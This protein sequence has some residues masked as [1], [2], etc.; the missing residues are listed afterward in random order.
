[1]V[2]LLQSDVALFLSFFGLRKQAEGHGSHRSAST[3]AGTAAL[4]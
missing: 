3:P 1:M 4:E 2:L